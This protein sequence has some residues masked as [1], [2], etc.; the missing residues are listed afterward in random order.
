[1]EL[2]KILSVG[3]FDIE[4]AYW[5]TN[6]PLTYLAAI[7]SD[8]GDYIYGVFPVDKTEFVSR[9]GRKAEYICMKDD[10]TLRHAFGKKIGGLDLGV[11]GGQNI[12]GFDYI[13]LDRNK[14]M[15]FLPGSD[16]SEAYKTRTRIGGIE[17]WRNNTSVDLDT[18]LIARNYLGM[19]LADTKLETI[20]ELVDHFFPSVN[21]QF[22][23]AYTHEELDLEAEKALKGDAKAAV[24]VIKYNYEDTIVHYELTKVLMPIMVNIA[25]ATESELFSAFNDSKAKLTTN[26]AAR[27]Y[28]GQ[29]HQI[30]PGSYKKRYDTF[31]LDDANKKTDKRKDILKEAIPGLEAKKGFFK[32]VFATFMPL[33]LAA[34]DLHEKDEP[35]KKLIESIAKSENPVEKIMCAQI[36]DRFSAEILADIQEAKINP[37]FSFKAKFGIYPDAAEKSF[38][39]GISELVSGINAGNI[40][41]YSKGLLFIEDSD[42]KSLAA[43]GYSN[44][45]NVDLLSVEESGV[46]YRHGNQ[47]FTSGIN[48]PSKKERQKL[49]YS[50]SKKGRANVETIIIRDFIEKFF[51][52]PEE[53]YS[54]L[55]DNALKIAKA[56][57]DLKHYIYTINIKQELEDMSDKEL[58]KQRNLVVRHFGAKPGETLMY[59]R[60]KSKKYM[61]YDPGEKKFFFIDSGK[62]YSNYDAKSMK[63]DNG[64]ELDTEYYHE[65]IF[66]ADSKFAKIAR[67]ALGKE[68]YDEFKDYVKDCVTNSVA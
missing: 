6:N 37:A 14:D 53:A 26:Y 25:R 5:W 68:K 22:T 18:M 21:L 9:S 67:T 23:K 19:F 40:V 15:T 3:A 20:A 10:I 50:N 11:F 47:I 39:S 36:M 51:A 16:N 24:E 59:I 7:V 17:R 27:K 41:N 2:E 30:M 60:T 32:N 54:E 1:M 58:N 13:R 45:G 57:F 46:I 43:K 48:I 44:I 42:G 35:K 61:A 49:D 8:K 12:L 63:F 38:K 62:K 33:Y 28:Y 29:M 55:C 4:L 52:N 64:D 34:K 66:G 56:G 65:K 31:K